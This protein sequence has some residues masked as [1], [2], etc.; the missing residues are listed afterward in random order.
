[1][2]EMFLNL[3]YL[4]ALEV[5]GFIIAKRNS[6]CTI[7]PLGNDKYNVIFEADKG[8]GQAAKANFNFL[9]HKDPV[10]I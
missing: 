4:N 8:H 9:K 10:V 1:M 7:L 5:A 3:K 6:S 2:K